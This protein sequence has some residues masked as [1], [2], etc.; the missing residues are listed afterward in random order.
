MTSAGEH[1]CKLEF[2]FLTARKCLGFGFHLDLQ[3][4]GGDQGANLI[5][6][7]GFACH[8]QLVEHLNM[9]VHSEVVPEDILLR[10]ETQSSRSINLNRAAG[11]GIE[12]CNR[13]QRGAFATSIGP[14]ENQ[15]L[16]SQSCE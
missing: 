16:A 15:N 4:T 1:H 14:K 8:F 6:R 7:V 10:T 11:D 12:S 3:I 5:F 9:L 2:T 13:I